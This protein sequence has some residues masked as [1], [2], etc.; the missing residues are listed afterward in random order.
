MWTLLTSFSY[1]CFVH[2]KSNFVFQTTELVTAISSDLTFLKNPK[3]K[4]YNKVTPGNNNSG[5][6]HEAD[7]H[8]GGQVSLLILPNLRHRASACNSSLTGLLQKKTFQLSLY[9]KV[10]DALFFLLKTN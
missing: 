3:P 9:S 2:L 10:S 7:R 1:I 5:E 8:T 4:A 6:R